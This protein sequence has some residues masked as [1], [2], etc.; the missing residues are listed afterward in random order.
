MNNKKERIQKIISNFG[1]YS[2]REFEKLILEGRVKIDGNVAKLGDRATI[3]SKIEI[4]NK[5]Q[6]L[7]LEHDYFLLNKPLGY[8]S[9]RIDEQGKEVISLIENKKNRNYFTIGRLDVNTSGLIIVTTDGNLSKIVNSPQSKIKKK[10]IVT[11]N[12]RLPNGFEE[13]L[14][15]GVILDDGYLTKKAIVKVVKSNDSNFSSFEITITEGKNNQIRRMIKS[16]GEDYSVKT[17][18]RIEIG[19]LKIGKISIGR[20][21]VLKKEEIYN[22]LSIPLF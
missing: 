14:S 13:Q 3:Y 4:D 15:K 10:Y 11:T 17:L 16:F 12:K 6:T 21:K 9:S 18:K 5:I 20:Y 22:S 1:S 7:N 2:R 19:S 8:I